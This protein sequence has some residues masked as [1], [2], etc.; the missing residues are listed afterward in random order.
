MPGIY[1]LIYTVFMMM[2]PEEYVHIPVYL[3][4]LHYTTF[5]ICN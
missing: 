3:I 5:L 4:Y 1:F 2:E